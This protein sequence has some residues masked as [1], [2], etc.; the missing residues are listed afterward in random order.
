MEHVNRDQLAY[1][2]WDASPDA[3]FKRFWARYY[4]MRGSNY[5]LGRDGRGPVYEPLSLKRKFMT[6]DPAAS[7]REGPGDD[8]NYA[9]TT[10]SSSVISVWGLTD[11]Y[12]LLWL[13]MDKFR[14]EIPEVIERVKYAFREW[15]P[16]SVFCDA[17]GLGKGVFQSLVRVGLPAQSILHKTDKVVN[18]TE[19]IIRMEQRRIW[20]PQSASWLKS[21]EDEVFAWTGHPKEPDDAVDTLADA[22]R[23]VSW[24]TAALDVDRVY[25]DTVTSGADLGRTDLPWIIN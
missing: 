15:M 22:A 5:V 24:D 19:A 7:S 21:C 25:L 4:S 3:R 2:E 17:S 9:Y 16:D 12:N 14:E 11:D 6:I 10:P 23:I 20:F 18:A 1:G 13:Y 8:E